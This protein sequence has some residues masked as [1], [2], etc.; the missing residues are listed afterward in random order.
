MLTVILVAHIIVSIVLIGVV[1]MQRSE[2]G[3]LG[4]G[5]GGGGGP[6]GGLVSGTGMKGALIRTTIIFG[7][8][9]FITSLGLTTISTGRSSDGQTDIQ[10]QLEEEFLPDA[11]E[12][13]LGLGTVEDFL[14]TG[15]SDLIDDPLAAPSEPSGTVPNSDAPADQADDPLRQ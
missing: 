11:T 13:D 8:I 3:A 7:A 2:G 4:I 10:R 14:D 12:D 5:G 6:G 15:T 1:L 9:F